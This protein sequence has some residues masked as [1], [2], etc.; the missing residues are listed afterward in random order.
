MIEKIFKYNNFGNAKG[1]TEQM[2][3]KLLQIDNELLMKFEWLVSYPPKDFKKTDKPV[4]LWLHDIPDD[5]YFDILKNDDFQ[6]Q[7]DYF[8]FVSHWQRTKF[9][10]KFRIPYSKCFIIKNA[11]DI[12]KDVDFN[13]FKSPEKIKICYT[14]APHKAVNILEP[15][16]NEIYNDFNDLVEFNIYSNFELYGDNHIL[17][18]QAFE[19]TYNKLKNSKFINYYG[20]LEHSK[21]MEELKTNHIFV[22]P[23]LFPETSC[24]SLIEALS[25]GCITV[26]NTL[27]ATY[28]TSYGFG[29]GFLFDYDQNINEHASNFYESLKH[30]VETVQDDNNTLITKLSKQSQF[31]NVKYDWEHRISDWINFLNTHN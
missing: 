26:F 14:S 8:I 18:N 31:I 20:Y 10:D 7:I 13:R 19:N 25:A 15:V 16:F 17:R 2:V 24:I 12:I 21:L 9:I 30:A 1:G 27:G 28:E 4:I 29:N 11:I 5:P 23:S 6:K 22:L 3:Q